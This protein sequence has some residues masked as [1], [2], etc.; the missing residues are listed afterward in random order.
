M[1]KR[2]IYLHHDSGVF[3]LIVTKQTF[4]NDVSVTDTI[5]VDNNSM[6]L[7]S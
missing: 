6:K 7:L 1:K 2:L 4:R 3:I 5:T